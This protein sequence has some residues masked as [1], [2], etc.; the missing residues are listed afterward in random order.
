MNTKI[1]TVGAGYSLTDLVSSN[2]VL[3]EEF[4]FLG[5][6]LGQES[7]AA[8][9]QQF[10]QDVQAAVKSCNI[11]LVVDGTQNF[12][13]KGIMARGFGKPLVQDENA[14]KA[15]QSYLQKSGQRG[16]HVS[17]EHAQIPQGAVLLPNEYG[18]D[19]GFLLLYPNICIAV[20]PAAPQ[21]LIHSLESQFFP[22]LMKSL[23]KTGYTTRVPLQPSK[24][25]Q[26]E[27]YIRQYGYSKGFLARVVQAPDGNWLRV[28]AV[29]NSPQESRQS[30]DSFLEDVTAEVGEISVI[31]G[32]GTRGT[33]VVEKK[34]N[35]TNAAIPNRLAYEPLLLD[36][37]DPLNG[38]GG[39]DSPKKNKKSTADKIKKALLCI[40]LL[41]FLG[42][43]GYLGWYY[44][45]SYQNKSAYNTLKDV[46]SENTIIAP[47]GYPKGY[48]K[49]FAALWKINPDIVGW[50]SIDDTALDYPVVQTKDNDKYYRMN[51][52]GSYSEHGVPFVDADV[53]LKEPSKNTIIYGHNIRT[54]GQMFNILRGYQKL[55]FYQAHPV[56]EFNNVYN[57]G[58]YV[59]FS[60]FYSSTRPEHGPIFPYIEFINTESDAETQSY[61]DGVTIRSIFNTGVDVKPSDELLTLS[62]CSYEYKDAR[63][64]VVARKLRDGESENWDTSKA[65]NNPSPLY[66]NVWYKV[67]GGTKPNVTDGPYNFSSGLAATGGSSSSGAT[68]STSG[69]GESASTSESTGTASGGDTSTA[70]NTQGQTQGSGTNSTQSQPQ[71]GGSSSTANQTQGSGTSNSTGGNTSGGTNNSTGG[72][73]SSGTN[74]SN[75]TPDKPKETT[76]PDKVED[77]DKDKD[78]TST[79]KDKETGEN[80]DSNKDKETNGDTNQTQDKETEGGSNTNTDKKEETD[81]D[82][83]KDKDKETGGNESNDGQNTS[84]QPD[85][86]PA[87]DNTNNPPEP[88][89]EDKTQSEGD[90]QKQEN[91]GD[92]TTGGENE[93]PEP[94]QT[95][96]GKKKLPQSATVV[97]EKGAIYVSS[98]ASD[99]NTYSE[100][101]QEDEQE[102]E[103]TNVP[104]STD[105]TNSPDTPNTSNK[106]DTTE[107]DSR[108]DRDDEENQGSSMN[109]GTLTVKYNGS[110]LTDSAAE[111]IG[112]IVEAE[113]GPTFQPEAIKAQAVAAY[114]YVRY[115]ND[116]GNVPSVVMKTPVS[117]KVRS[118]V[119]SVIGKAVYYNGSVIEATY[120]A[121]SAG[122]TNS[123]VDYWGGNGAPY[124]VSV[125]SPGDERVKAFGATK[126]YSESEIADKIQ[127]YYGIDPYEYGDPSDWFSGAEYVNGRYVRR[128]QVCGKSV[129]GRDIRDGLLNYGLKSTAFEVDYNGSSFTFT[130][131]GYGHGVGL[132]QQGADYYA[133]QGWSYQDILTH[134]YSGTSVY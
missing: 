73:T 65:V 13:T 110:T 113:M 86:D 64:V 105:T 118:A 20:L 95:S 114:S 26:V 8:N 55:D 120:Y 44:Y 81:K 84:G 132:S 106:E 126:T 121:S 63:F 62:T 31:R 96:T 80:T 111:I 35:Q 37:D 58:K 125:D 115:Y 79:D 77:K 74:N 30:C 41:I 38:V 108:N 32:V 11:L 4:Q 27:E 68:D 48:D 103:N 131:Y 78:T 133:M 130:T 36:D 61:I 47:S 28:A 89:P 107:N 50:L 19:Q 43:G 49:E 82:K 134:Y 10:M 22:L 5:V 117:S 123:A 92:G 40:C 45:Q 116:K 2:P 72:N 59:I 83:D 85:P 70:S 66:P 12:E 119:A 53:D 69:T 97:L 90:S 24:A 88:N 21:S 52:E 76:T 93:A 127:S 129:T 1:I 7:T 17:A 33:K 101:E 39:E 9:Q 6:E 71:G 57:K 54:D 14:M 75:T 102:Q 34:V 25:A 99:D 109:A 104:D 15:I 23:Y 46:Y 29:R 122:Q 3:S 60:V 67:F 87:P 98:L 94:T 91:Q 42:A 51:F 56:V 18:V 16:Q 112:G 100:S 124:L 128:I